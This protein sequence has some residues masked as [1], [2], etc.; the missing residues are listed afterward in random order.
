MSIEE[1]RMATKPIEKLKEVLLDNSKLD[2]TTKIDRK[3]VV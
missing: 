1:H 3:S 2:L